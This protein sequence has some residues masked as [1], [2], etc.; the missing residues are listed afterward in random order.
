MEH[1]FREIVKTARGKK[2]CRCVSKEVSNTYTLQKMHQVCSQCNAMLARLSGHTVDKTSVV[3]KGPNNPLPKFLWCATL[4]YFL[5]LL[6]LVSKI[7]YNG[8]LFILGLFGLN[9][10]EV[11]NLNTYSPKTLNV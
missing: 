9:Y 8:S 11:E 2:A 7:L 6:L 1:I 3:T 10:S 4:K 5:T